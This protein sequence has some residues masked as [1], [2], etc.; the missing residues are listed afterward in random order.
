MSNGT[1]RAFVSTSAHHA[2]L[3]DPRTREEIQRDDDRKRMPGRATTA[4][5]GL[6]DQ[7]AQARAALTRGDRVGS[8]DSATSRTTSS[9]RSSRAHALLV[10]VPGSRRRCSCTVAQALD[11]FS[12]VQFTLDLMPTTS[13]DG[14]RGGSRHRA[15]VLL[16][17]GSR[18][19]KRGAGGRDQLRATE[20]RCTAQ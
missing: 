18:V 1:A 14:P 2:S 19:W 17:A 10:G 9:R 12:R 4:R 7:L 15:S 6:L 16:P 11:Q 8:S 13:R 20:D 5:R 3:Q